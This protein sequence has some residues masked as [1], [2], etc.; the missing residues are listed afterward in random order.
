MLA[1]KHILRKFT[2]V[3]FL[4]FYKHDN[5]TRTIIHSDDS[6]P[7]RSN[8]DCNDRQF[9]EKVNFKYYKKVYCDVTVDKSDDQKVGYHLWSMNRLQ[10]T[11]RGK[12]YGARCHEGGSLNYSIICKIPCCRRSSHYD[13]RSML[14][15]VSAFG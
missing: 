1:N 9:L 11:P 8:V 5:F 13:A 15:V 2:F 7:Q 14:V 12:C 4:N 3:L 6:A 10:S